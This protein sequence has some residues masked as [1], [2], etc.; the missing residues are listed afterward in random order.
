MHRPRRPGEGDRAQRR[1]HHLGHRLRAL[2]HR[3]PRQ[4]RL[5]QVPQRRHEPRDGAHPRRQRPHDGA[6]RRPRDGEGGG[7]RR[8]R[9]L[10]RLQGHRGR[11]ALLQPG[12]LP[13]R[14]EAD[15]APQGQGRRRR[16]PLHRHPGPRPPVRGVLR[17]NPGERRRLLQ[18]EGD[19]DRPS[20]R[21]GT[22]EG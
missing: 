9:P 16:H 7:E 21:P 20:G 3:E 19:G 4:L 12:L 6:A 13:L 18:G 10:R 5:R 11:Q 2:R 8:L 1:R 17:D 22:R 15:A 14:P